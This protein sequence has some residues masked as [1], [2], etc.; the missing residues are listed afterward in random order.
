MI[1][2]RSLWEK[3]FL[4]IVSMLFALVLAFNL[5]QNTLSLSFFIIP[6][7]LAAS[8]YGLPGGLGC[9]VLSAA[10][11]AAIAQRSGMMLKDPQLLPQIILYFLVGG[12]GGFMQQ[13]QNRIQRMF[14]LSSITDELTGL[15]NYQHFR[16]RL[17]EEVRRAKRYGHPLSLLMCDI[18]QFKRYNDTYGHMNGN[19]ILN[20]TAS[21]IKDSIRESDIPFRY[22]GDEFAVILPETGMDAQG[23]AERI[24]KAVNSAFSPQKGDPTMRPSITAGVAAR[25]AERP[26]SASLL[27]SFADQALY[28]AKTSGAPFAIFRVGDPAVEKD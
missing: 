27:I 4:F 26:L 16:T 12:F 20:K 3:M 17:D 10:L 6:I 15:Y 18:N 21:L 5:P 2:Q 25:D 24:V 19:F 9:A 23:V 11:A 14:H 22:G 28:K 7:I 13:E 1:P 8:Y